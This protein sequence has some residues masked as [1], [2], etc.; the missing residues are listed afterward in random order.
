MK[1][2]TR[3]LASRRR[4]LGA[5]AAAGA[6]AFLRPARGAA[7]KMT[8]T[9]VWVQ[10]TTG[11]KPYPPTFQ[12][13]FLDP[14][15]FGMEIWPIDQPA[16]FAALLPA[17]PAPPPARGVAPTQGRGALGGGTERDEPPDYPWEPSGGRP[18]PGY[19]VLVLNDQMEWPEATRNLARQAV[20]AGRGCDMH[21]RWAT[22]RL[23]GGIKNDRRADGAER[24]GG[25]SVHG[26]NAAS[27]AC[28]RRGSTRS[29]GNK[30]SPDQQETSRHVQSPKITPPPGR[31]PGATP[32]SQGSASIPARES[33]LPRNVV[34]TPQLSYRCS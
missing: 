15:F 18:H 9:Q 11:G 1:I 27:L 4:F 28:V 2:T 25:R 7:Q 33:L 10:L 21:H 19:D 29:F 8:K 32:R 16:S 13:M 34:K 30:P 20:E 14:M 5:T 12:E 26:R 31:M 23:P 6:A 22:T 3:T 17:A 24:R